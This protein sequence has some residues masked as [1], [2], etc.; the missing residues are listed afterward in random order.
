MRVRKARRSINSLKINGKSIFEDSGF[1][2]QYANN[3]SFKFLKKVHE[4]LSK[5]P[6]EIGQNTD[7]SALEKDL[8]IALRNTRWEGDSANLSADPKLRTMQGGRLSRKGG[9]T[10]DEAIEIAVANLQNEI[11]KHAKS[12]ANKKTEDNPNFF[13]NLWKMF[14]EAFSKLGAAL[15]GYEKL[16]KNDVSNKGLEDKSLQANLRELS[17]EEVSEKSPPPTATPKSRSKVKKRVVFSEVVHTK[18]I[19]GSE[20][21]E[22]MPTDKSRGSKP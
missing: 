3:E 14:S 11:K 8:L 6:K 7:N 5:I 12:S 21:E 1:S 2:Q 13:E 20:R 16:Q 22:P 4:I 10:I 9:N 15:S 17:K 18:S 19:G